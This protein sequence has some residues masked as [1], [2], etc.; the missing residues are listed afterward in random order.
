MVKIKSFNLVICMSTCAFLPL[1]A[2]ASSFW[3]SSSGSPIKS[4]S[5]VCVVASLATHEVAAC[6]PTDRVILLPGANG[7]AGAVLISAKGA[8][9]RLDQAYKTVSNSQG[10]LSEET[11]SAS[12]VSNEFGQLLNALP[13]SVTSFTVQFISGSATELTPESATVITQLIAEIERREAPEIRLVGHTDS[14]GE[15]LKNDLL[16][17]QRA[18]TV[19]SVLIEQGIKPE[20]IEATGRGERE[21]AVITADNVNEAANRRVD[22][23]VR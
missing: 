1:S 22:I 9:H 4:S 8:T 21:P 10:N 12:E 17:K 18:Q 7:K 5:G 3:Q 23:R 13:Q 15:L 11:V 6:K 14:V 20:S 2:N 19:V 16:S